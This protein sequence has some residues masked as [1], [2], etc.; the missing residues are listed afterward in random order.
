MSAAPPC[1]CDVVNFDWPCGVA[2]SRG[3]FRVPACPGALA[4]DP[5]KRTVAARLVAKTRAR[6]RRRSFPAMLAQQ[7]LVEQQYI[8]V[9][10]TAATPPRRAVGSRRA[11]E[12]L[13]GKKR[14]VENKVRHR[15]RWK[16]GEVDRGCGGC[17]W[18]G[19]RTG[20]YVECGLGRR[21]KQR[22]AKS[23]CLELREEGRKR[24]L[25]DTTSIIHAYRRFS[26]RHHTNPF[27]PHLV[28][29]S[30]SVH[31]PTCLST[32]DSSGQPLATPRLPRRY[33]PLRT[34]FACGTKETRPLLS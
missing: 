20:D 34:N 4:F 22:G 2:G 5:N 13:A 33:P 10:R 23:S 3:G 30:C 8:E 25:A 29:S 31:S 18:F 16:C 12:E 1:D 27:T 9:A 32:A 28:S 24:S 15:Q 14:C 21:Q 7:S 26:Y 19:V 6:R 11:N 17:T